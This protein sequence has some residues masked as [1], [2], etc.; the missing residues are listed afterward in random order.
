MKRWWNAGVSLKKNVTACIS[1]HDMDIMQAAWESERYSGEVVLPK[2]IISTQTAFF[3]RI[4]Q[5]AI[6]ILIS[7]SRCL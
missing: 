3:P 7:S 2:R 4:M 6:V 5:T 1:G